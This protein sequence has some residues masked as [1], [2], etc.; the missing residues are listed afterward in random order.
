[1]FVAWISRF[2]DNRFWD[3]GN[4]STLLSLTFFSL[5]DPYRFCDLP[6]HRVISVKRS[7]DIHGETGDVTCMDITAMSPH[8]RTFLSMF[9]AASVSTPGCFSDVLMA[10]NLTDELISDTCAATRPFSASATD[11]RVGV[12]AL[13]FFKR[14]WPC[15]IRFRVTPDCSTTLILRPV[16]LISLKNWFLNWDL[17]VTGTKITLSKPT[18]LYQVSRFPRLSSARSSC[19]Q[20]LGRYN[21]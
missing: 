1:M 10:A 21:G 12:F 4:T 20:L 2:R 6:Q 3:H 19:F 17:G 14:V 18:F 5:I 8:N 11:Q 15:N 7:C 13:S 9:L 16:S